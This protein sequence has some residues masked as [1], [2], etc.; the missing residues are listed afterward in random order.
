[1]NLRQD[2]IELNIEALTALANA[3]FVK[4]AQKDL[5]EGRLPQIEYADDGCVRARYEDGHCASL[6]AAKSLREALRSFRALP[7]EEQAARLRERVDAP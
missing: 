7:P 4:R 6:A 5:A 3:G 2:L 1:M